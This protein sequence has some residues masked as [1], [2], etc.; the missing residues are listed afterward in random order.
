MFI[1]ANIYA[2]NQNNPT[3]FLELFRD[4]DKFEGNQILIGDFSLTLEPQIT[5]IFEP[6]VTMTRLHKLM[7]AY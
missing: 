6:H 1:L 2:P 3:F 5:E 4:L 7:E